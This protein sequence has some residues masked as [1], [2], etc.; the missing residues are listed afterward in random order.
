VHPSY[1]CIEATESILMRD[2]DATM[3]TLKQLRELGV[4]LSI[5]DFGTGYSSLS[6]L[7]RFPI[8]QLKIDR[9][10]VNEVAVNSDDAAI[11]AAIASLARSLSL[12]V[13]AE[14][15][16]TVEQA[17]LLAKQGCHIM[18]GYFFSKPLLAE[19]LT[20]LL[21]QGAAFNLHILE[22]LSESAEVD[23][24]MPSAASR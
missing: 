4:K 3:T 11:V 22:I 10:F 12:D 6:Y 8:D 5:D 18:Q 2:A 15:V 14:G 19:E 23:D 7:R 24:E 13:V 20:P 21:A 1:L 17:R 9:S 16:E